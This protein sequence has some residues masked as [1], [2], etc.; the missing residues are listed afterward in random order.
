MADLPPEP[1]PGGEND[2]TGTP[3]WVKVFGIIAFVVVLAFII[4]HLTGHGLGGHMHRL[5]VSEQGVKRP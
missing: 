2:D 5:P 4:L 1:E 3:R